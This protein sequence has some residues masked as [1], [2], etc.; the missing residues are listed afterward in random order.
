MKTLFRLFRSILHDDFQQQL[1]YVK[2]ELC[3]VQ[4]KT[5]GKEIGQRLGILE[6]LIAECIEKSRNLSYQINP[7]ALYRNGLLTALNVLVKQIEDK[8]G[9]RVEVR[10][11][12]SAEPDSLTL[13]SILYRAARELLFNVAKHAGVDSAV[14]D[15]RSKNGMIHIQVEDSG[16][17]FDY[18]TV[19][20]SQGTGAGFGLY[21]IEDRVTFFGGSMKIKTAPGKGCCVVLTV[22]KDVSRKTARSAPPPEETVKQESM[23][24]EPAEDTQSFDDRGQIRILLADDHELMREALAKLLQGC[25]ELTI[26]GQAI[27]GREVIQLAAQLKPHVI[28]MDVTMPKLD[29][30][31]ATAQITRDQPDIRIIGLSMHSDADT[32][33]KMLHAGASAYLTKT[34]SPDTLVETIRRVHYGTK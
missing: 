24:V 25:K 6:Q 22:P 18:D 1:A 11:Q 9:L 27:D 16:N 2:M 29:G 20:S 32:R 7:P 12:P 15:V 31:E 13:A 21:S 3:L 10:T 30:I 5:S 34:G 26:V 17:G 33:K 23:G 8:H 19:W 14:M 28:L 4:K